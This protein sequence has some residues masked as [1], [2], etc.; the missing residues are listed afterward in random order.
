MATDGE[1]LLRR[2]SHSHR[3]L[4]KVFF[5]IPTVGTRCG[6][7]TINLKVVSG[8]ERVSLFRLPGSGDIMRAL[9]VRYAIAD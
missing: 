2:R 6:E 4:F 7:P 3:D 8:Q 9:V 1:N 5:A